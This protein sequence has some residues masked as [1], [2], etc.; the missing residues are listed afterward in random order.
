VQGAAATAAVSAVH[1]AG[2]GTADAGAAG[3]PQQ[4]AAAASR[5]PH[6]AQTGQVSAHSPPVHFSQHIY[7]SYRGGHHRRKTYADT[8]VAVSTAAERS[9]WRK[10]YF[11][12]TSKGTR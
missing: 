9:L 4:G 8:A 6:H 7:K 11:I 5:A 1:G 10:L 3:L 12:H 2:R